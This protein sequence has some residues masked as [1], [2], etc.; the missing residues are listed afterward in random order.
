MEV[1]LLMLYRLVTGYGGEAITSSRNHWGHVAA[2]C[3]FNNETALR[4]L[5][6]AYL[7]AFE[8]Y[9]VAVVFHSEKLTVVRRKY[10]LRL[11]DDGIDYA[12]APGMLGFRQSSGGNYLLSSGNR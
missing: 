10:F 11:G 4:D 3:G 7:F 2:A 8:R 5:Y 12:P 1:N 9:G 6:L